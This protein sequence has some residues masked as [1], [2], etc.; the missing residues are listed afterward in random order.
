MV[1]T[2]SDGALFDAFGSS[3]SVSSIPSSDLQYACVGA[4]WAAVNVQA[5]AGAAYV[6]VR[7][8]A[9]TWTELHKLTAPTP[10]SRDQFGS[11]SVLD[12]SGEWLAIGAIGVD[13]PGGHVD[14]AGSVFV[15]QRSGTALSATWSIQATVRPPMPL[16]S[17]SFGTAMAMDY[18]GQYLLVGAP[19][20]NR[21]VSVEATGWSGSAYLFYRDAGDSN[22][23]KIVQSMNSSDSIADDAFG[24]AVSLSAD[25]LVA[26]IGALGRDDNGLFSAG[27]AYMYRSQVCAAPSVLPQCRNW[28]LEA[29]VRA[30]NAAAGDRFGSAL[31][32]SKLGDTLL[33]GAPGK[34]TVGADAGSAY[35]FTYHTQQWLQQAQLAVPSV[36]EGAYFGYDLSLLEDGSAAVVG[37]FHDAN[38][39]GAA[40]ILPAAGVWDCVACGTGEFSV[41][42]FLCA[43]STAECSACAPGRYSTEPLR[44]SRVCQSCGVGTYS[45]LQGASSINDCLPCQLGSFTNAT[46]STA[47][48]LCYPGR[49]A[50]SAGTSSC[51]LCGKDSYSPTVGAV[52]AST[53]IACPKETASNATGA[54]TASVCVPINPVPPAADPILSAIAVGVIIGFGTVCCLTCCSFGYYK[55]RQRAYRR[56]EKLDEK[57]K[58]EREDRKKNKGSDSDSASD[59][60]GDDGID[61]DFEA[62]DMFLA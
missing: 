19:R 5:G 57:R 48:A 7:T 34:G 6:Y 50:E 58:K 22:T 8:S 2:A 61:A 55:L 30:T 35:I 14:N 42:S 28:Q 10:A 52:N 13:N 26:A 12:N 60:E 25:G 32:L 46:E 59:M 24:S 38:T 31:S 21:N 23:W 45:A 36:S 4:P 40:Y 11:A 29:Y 44:R 1:L 39:N 41:S 9:A 37:A 27:G 3:V 15:F 33:V 18:F 51:T 62:M 43:S 17:G 47:C 49:F 53:C 56:Q 20:E 16:Y 54:S